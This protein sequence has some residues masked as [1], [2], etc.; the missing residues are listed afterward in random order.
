MG[1][2]RLGLLQGATGLQVGGDAGGP[3]SVGVDPAGEV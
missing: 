2:D 3:G 1:G